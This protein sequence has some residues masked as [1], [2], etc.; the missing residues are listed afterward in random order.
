[1]K[2]KLSFLCLLCIVP[3][4]LAWP[5]GAPPE[6]CDSLMPN[7]RGT[8]SGPSNDGFFLLGDVFNG[9]YVPGMTYESKFGRPYKSRLDN[10]VLI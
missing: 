7:H 1:M 2:M 4:L 3:S 6:A 10:G 9:S 8:Q 5:T